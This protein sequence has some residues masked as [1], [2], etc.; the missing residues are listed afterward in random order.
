LLVAIMFPE[1]RTKVETC[2]AEADCS[3]FARCFVELG[4]DGWAP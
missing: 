4:R 3:G 2:L 1:R